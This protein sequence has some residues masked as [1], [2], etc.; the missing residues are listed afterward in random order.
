M[1]ACILL[2]G[3][4]RNFKPFIKNQLRCVIDKYKLDVFIYTSDEN[5]LRYSAS[6]NTVI[7]YKA[8]PSFETDEDFFRNAYSASIK[9][10]YIDHNN[11]RFTEFLRERNVT[12]HRNHTVN[13]ISS[14]FKINGCISL[15]ES[16]EKQHGFR[17]DIVMRC[18][19]DFYSC[20]D[21]FIDPY[22]LNLDTVYFPVSRF[23]HHKDDSGF[24]MKREFI[25]DCKDFIDVIIDF[26]D[27]SEY[28]II[29]E[30]FHHYMKSKHNIVYIPN[31]AY[32]IGLGCR[33]STIPYIQNLDLL[34]SLEY[35]N[36][37]SS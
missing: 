27:T 18:R 35:H 13:M 32:R 12:K 14:Y 25:E 21:N 11:E 37:L 29:E 20:D 23:N 33:P 19:L 8:A 34:H 5:V 2:S 17:Y 7:D 10:I 6:G 24:I 26:D 31:F 1:K 22:Q 30:Q 16:Y 36:E 3:L 4:Q 15:M 28:I 9:G